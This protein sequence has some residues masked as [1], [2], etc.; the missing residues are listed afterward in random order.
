MEYGFDVRFKN[1]FIY[2]LGGEYYL[3]GRCTCERCSD[4]KKISLYKEFISV[5]D[6][7][8]FGNV[9]FY[10]IKDAHKEKV[11]DVYDRLHKECE[12]SYEERRVNDDARVL[13]DKLKKQHS[14]EIERQV[15]L[16]M[17]ASE[18]STW[19]HVTLKN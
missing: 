11:A 7:V 6:N 14:D 9:D 16:M 19:Y 2:E 17:K 8:K 10:D 15:K 1:D 12:I 4:Y 5:C 18:C 13:F 3:I